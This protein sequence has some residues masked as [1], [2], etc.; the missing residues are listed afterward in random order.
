VLWTRYVQLT[1][2]ESVPIPEK[3]LGIR[4]IYH[5]L[6][7]RADAHVLIAFLAYCLQVTLKNR[8]MIHAPGLTPAGVRK[9]GHDSDGGGVDSDA[10]R[11]LA[12]AAAPHTAGPMCRP[13]WSRSASRC[14]LNHRR[15][16][17]PRNCRAQHESVPCLCLREGCDMKWA[18]LESKMLSAAAY[19][20]S[21]Q[22]LYLRFRNTGDVYRYFEFTAADIRPSSVQNRRAA[23]SALTSAITSAT[24]AWP[25]STP[26]DFLLTSKPLS[27]H[28]PSVV[29]TF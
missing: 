28:P 24:S 6:E 15:E 5:Q 13:C 23:F 7:H 17:S 19:D 1:Q 4:P 2:I 14:R 29:E 25:G 21:K 9:A 27:G 8:L 20:D 11:A 3:R 18:T 22:V 16:S 10:R 12:G 26:P